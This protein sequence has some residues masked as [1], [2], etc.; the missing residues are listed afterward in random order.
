MP[1]RAKYAL[2]DAKTGKE[3]EPGGRVFGSIESLK[4]SAGDTIMSQGGRQSS[5]FQYEKITT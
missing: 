2:I 3:W 1:D 5:Q 4:A